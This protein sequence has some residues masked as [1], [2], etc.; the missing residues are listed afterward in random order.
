M[1]GSKEIGEVIFDL[2]EKKKISISELARQVGAAKSSM[3]RYKNG[4][5]EFPVNDIGKY[6]SALNVSPEYLLGLEQVHEIRKE[7]TYLPTTISAGLP[8]N[9]EAITEADNISIPDSIMGKWAGGK[10]IMILNVNGDS[11]D[12]IIPDGSLI[13]VKPIELTELKNGDIVVFSNGYE[14]SVKRY[15]KHDDKLVFRPES[16]NLAHYDQTYNVTDDIM[17]HGKV[18]VYIVELD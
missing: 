5:R 15:Y 8:L 16:S 12:K 3:S 7:Y 18:V 1:R 9:V 10:D 2:V 4:E 13:A 6:A 11:M 17:V 14:Y